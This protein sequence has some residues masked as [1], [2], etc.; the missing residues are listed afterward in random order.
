MTVIVESKR[1]KVTSA[2]R[3]FVVR[4]TQKL[5]KLHKKTTTVRVNLETVKKKSN[6]PLANSAT[7]RVHIPGKSLVVTR[8]AVTMYD[9]IVDA[10]KAATR[11]LRKHHEKRFTSRRT[12]KI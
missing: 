7:F 6:D 10:A 8:K 2:L 4:Q 1:M 5:A 3:E 11:Q 12:A 9:A